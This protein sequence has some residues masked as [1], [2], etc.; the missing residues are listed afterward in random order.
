MCGIVG[1]ISHKN[2]IVEY[3]VDGLKRLEYRGYDSA[4]I[5]TITDG[6]LERRRSV[7]KLVN[8]E[9]FL[10]ENPLSGT[11]GIAHT[12]WATHGKADHLNAHPHSNTK[13]SVVH[14]GIIENFASLKQDLIQKG[15]VFESETDT[16]VIVHLLTECLKENIS[17]VE[18]FQKTLSQLHGAFALVV[19]L[20]DYPDLLLAARFGSPLVLGY[21]DDEMYVG[22]DA[23]A[24]APWTSTLCYLEEGDLAVIDRSNHRFLIDLYNK[25][26]QKVERP[27]HKTRFNLEAVSKGN[28][29]HFMLKEIHE[30]PKSLSETLQSFIDIETYEA[31]E[32]LLAIPAQNLKR[33]VL[34][35]C[36]TSYYACMVAKYWFEGIAKISVDVDIASEFR[37]RKPVLDQYDL[38]IVVSQSGETIDTL[39][40]VRQFKES[41]VK[42]AAVVN[43]EESS[44][45][46]ES[47]FVLH[48][49]AGPEIGV[50]S[51]KAFTSQ[52]LTFAVLALWAAFKKGHV[53]KEAW[54]ESVDSFI[55]LPLEI[56]S[57]LKLDE[58]IQHISQKL[59][60]ARDVLYLG[61][62]TNY[63]IALEGALKL[64]ELSYIHAESYPAGELKHG[65]IALIDHQMPVIVMCPYDE[66][67]LKTL[68]NV[69]EIIARGA[70]V[71]A[72]TDQEGHEHFKQQALKN[73][74]FIILDAF[75]N[76]W[77][78]PILY[79]IPIQLLAYYTAFFKG[80][81]VDKPRNL[82]KS[83]TV[84]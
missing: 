7:G 69:Q 25:E 83:V 26:G 79:S 32:S 71:I 58:D 16:E 41:N 20:K 5:A 14:N 4:G 55:K 23:L 45:A 34:I 81:D 76:E 56:L 46:R 33:I 29:S 39:W 27:L 70:Y 11:I 50:A 10:K 19:L 67:F 62:G 68:S 78:T 60:T 47:D 80:T 9:A 64:K 15:Y 18:A 63:P 30:Q 65:P 49:Q 44:I 74:D 22:S 82:A 8:L 77:T 6:S 28:F 72:I 17:P 38:A 73:T 51:T 53:S 24:L 35:A 12:R 42:V 66:W 52:L 37:Y 1:I 43:V 31:R 13:V 61:R 54:K 2:N 59:V 36:G 3:L 40:T 75:K 57:T 48:T 21:G 84:E